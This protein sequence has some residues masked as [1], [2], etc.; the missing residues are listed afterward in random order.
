MTPHQIVAVALRLL[1]LWL[2][3]GVLRIVPSFFVIGTSGARGSA[4]TLFTLGVTAVFVIGLW[5]FPHSIAGKLLPS[6]STE[7]RSPTASDTWLAM[8]CSL[9]GLWILTTT[10]PRLAVDL[11]VLSYM[12]GADDY[13]PVRRSILY[14][15]AEAVI[16]LWLICGAKGFRKVFW[17]AQ[18][19]GTDKSI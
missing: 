6:P 1:A 16:A 5:F 12:P 9:I 15:F 7:A 2:G 4:Y 13:S 18:S 3:I 19:A 17:W 11:Y 10:V 8:G 14:E